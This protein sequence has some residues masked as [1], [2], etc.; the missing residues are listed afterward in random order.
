MVAVAA[1]AVLILLS[2]QWTFEGAAFAESA[3]FRSL[4]GQD[5]QQGLSLLQAAA[6][7]QGLE[8]K[9]RQDLATVYL[10][11]GSA[12]GG[13][14][15]PGFKATS[16]AALTVDPQEAMTLDRN[17]LFGLGVQALLSARSRAPL[18]AD[19]YDQLGD[20]YLAWG[21]PRLAQAA[22]QRAETLS[23][24]NPKYLAG[25]AL[26]EVALGHGATA[27]RLGQEAVRLD[28]R[29]WYAHAALARI[30]HRLGNRQQAQHEA[31]LALFWEPVSRT[32]PPRSQLDELRRLERSG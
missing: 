7:W 6:R 29:Y 16:D 1:A 24:H 13:S 5:V 25:Q 17:Q 18:N 26:A 8:A 3:G 23:A 15:Q 28:P 20:A 27:T 14:A 11:L 21:R 2:G 19:I 31:T 32:T 4:S 9:Y 12:A 10:G 22:W 30:Y